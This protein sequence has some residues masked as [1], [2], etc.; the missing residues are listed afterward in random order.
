MI[1]DIARANQDWETKQAESRDRLRAEKLSAI[2][3][4]N[5]DYHIDPESQAAL[6]RGDRQR[7]TGIYQTGIDYIPPCLAK[8]PGEGVFSE[9]ICSL[10]NGHDGLHSC[11]G[12]G[13][14]QK[15]WES[16]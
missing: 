3:V 8:I 15:T 10:D 5:T 13:Y 2:A 4:D 12:V 16:K 9:H 7:E 11:V 14:C 6:D 1:G